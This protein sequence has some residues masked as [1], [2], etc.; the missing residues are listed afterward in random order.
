MDEL[1]V[2]VAVGVIDVF[3]MD[4]CRRELSSCKHCRLNW[5]LVAKVSYSLK[6]I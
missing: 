2:F 4:V 6:T 1:W 5:V 3:E